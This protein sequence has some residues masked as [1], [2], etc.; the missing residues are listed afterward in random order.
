MK[1]KRLD[2]VKSFCEQLLHHVEHYTIPQYGDYPDDYLSRM[3][4]TDCMKHIQKYVIRNDRGKVNGGAPRQ[5][6]DMLKI[7]HYAAHAY[8]LLRDRDGNSELD[9]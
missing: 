5:C 9:R 2:D 4:V 7:A 6:Q 1:S 8:F 3:T